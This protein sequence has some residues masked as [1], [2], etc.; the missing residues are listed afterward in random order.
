MRFDIPQDYQHAL[1]DGPW[2]VGDHYLHVQAWEEDFHPHVAKIST[3]AI[4]I[5]LEQLPIE[6]YHPEFLKHVGNKLGKL[7]KIDV[8]TSAVMRG[9]FARL[10]VQ[11]NT[12]YPLPKRVKIGAFWQD[13][14]YENLPM[15]CYRCSRI[16]HRE[17]HCTEPSQVLQDMDKPGVIIR[18]ESRLQ[19][20]VQ[21]HT[22]WKTVQT[23]RLRPRGNQ[24]DPL[25]RCKPLPCD[26]PT[27]HSQARCTDSIR[28]QLL[29]PHAIESVRKPNVNT[30]GDPSGVTCEDVDA[31]G[32]TTFSLRTRTPMH[33]MHVHPS[34]SCPRQPTPTPSPKGTMQPEAQLPHTDTPENILT[35]TS[36]THGSLIGPKL[37]HPHSNRPRPPSHTHLPKQPKPAT[38]S[39]LELPHTQSPR[40]S[41]GYGRTQTDMEWALT[42]TLRRRDG[43]LCPHPGS[44]PNCNGLEP[45]N[46]NTGLAN[47]TRTTSP[48]QSLPDA[49]NPC[50]SASDSASI[51]GTN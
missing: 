31:L 29:Q 12:T 20:P 2:F 16:G 24:T 5:H 15:L 26:D 43:E 35:R 19:E 3:T 30:S 8:V 22:P 11:V 45:G 23:R 50:T 32:K 44:P 41:S 48:T 36:S 17:N 28:V 46:P 27:S 25:H 14:V 39:D 51:P 21:N 4:W 6:Y 40:S 10:C 13:I 18:D 47:A 49:S 33:S 1:M 34:S 9:R 7:L 38:H 37:V 42:G